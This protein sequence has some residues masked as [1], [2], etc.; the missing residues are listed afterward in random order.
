ML[1]LYSSRRRQT[2]CALVTVVQ[3]FALPI[4]SRHAVITIDGPAGAGKSTVARRLA[5]RLGYDYVN[6]GAIDRKSVVSG[7]S[8]SVRGDLG[9]CS[10]IKNKK[11][12][13]IIL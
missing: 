7:R 11:Q 10:T 3:T 12:L 5:R 1:F 4:L 13:K 8:V 2:R 9:G 6:S